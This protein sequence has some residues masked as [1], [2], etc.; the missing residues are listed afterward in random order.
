MD[1]EEDKRPKK[2]DITIGEDLAMLSVEELRR[3]IAVLNAEIERLKDAIAEK[4][5]S[6]ETANSV[7]K[8]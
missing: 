5:K 4:E 1:L 3:R 2:P 7:F 8:L 6:R